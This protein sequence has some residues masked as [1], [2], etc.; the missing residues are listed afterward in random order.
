LIYDLYKLG[1]QA[2]ADI[3]SGNGWKFKLKSAQKKVLVIA[4]KI[5]HRTNRTVAQ[6]LDAKI[7]SSNTISIIQV[8]K[9]LFFY[10]C[11]LIIIL[12]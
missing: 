10:V 1:S 5:K 7:L 6:S 2:E 11:F 8:V 3:S 12:L 9:V 4:I